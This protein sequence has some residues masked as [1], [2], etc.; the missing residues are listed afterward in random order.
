MKDLRIEKY[1]ILREMLIN[2][3]KPWGFKMLKFYKNLHMVK[4]K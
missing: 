1:E 4:K 3:Y 2:G